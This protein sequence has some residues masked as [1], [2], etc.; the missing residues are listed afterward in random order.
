MKSK[1]TLQIRELLS[2]G[3]WVTVCFNVGGFFNWLR[4]F[5]IALVRHQ[6]TLLGYLL[7][8]CW[9]WS[10]EY[11]VA[12]HQYYQTGVGGVSLLNSFLWAVALVLV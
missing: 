1:G 11:L 7:A 2:I 5:F 12:D 8:H 3:I 4:K 10:L 6:G 9:R